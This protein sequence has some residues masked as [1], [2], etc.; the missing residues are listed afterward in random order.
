MIS[1]LESF[2]AIPLMAQQM[3]CKLDLGRPKPRETEW[4]LRL[5]ALTQR[6]LNMALAPAM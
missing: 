1:R 4:L 5:T 3:K 2:L 6:W